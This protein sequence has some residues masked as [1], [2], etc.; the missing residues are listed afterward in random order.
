MADGIF[1]A[2]EGYVKRTLGPLEARLAALEARPTPDYR[3]VWREGETYAAG[4]LTTHGG[5]MWFATEETKAR[6]GTGKEWLLCVK[7]GS[8]PG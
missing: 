3:G 6:P 2:V 4:S 1:K 5:S 7:K 8:L